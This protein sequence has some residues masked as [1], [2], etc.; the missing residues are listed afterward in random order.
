M[1]VLSAEEYSA[2]NDFLARFGDVRY[3]IYLQAKSIQKAAKKLKCR[4]AGAYFVIGPLRGLGCSIPEIA[5]RLG[6]SQPG[7]V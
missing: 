6:M 1:G 7:L 5:G 3:L 4:P 2:Q